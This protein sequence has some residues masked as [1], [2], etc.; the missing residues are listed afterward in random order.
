LVPFPAATNAEAAGARPVDLL[1]DES[2][3]IPVCQRIDDACLSGAGGERR[4]GKRVGFHVDHHE[5]LARRDRLQ[6]V[7]DPGDRISGRLDHNVDPVLRDC[8]VGARGD[9]DGFDGARV[10]AEAGEPRGDALR[11]EVGDRTYR[12]SWHGRRL[13]EEHG[14]ELAGSDQSHPYWAG[15]L[16][17]LSRE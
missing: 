10:P 7:I 2:R 4:P 17:P 14:A 15:L 12:D 6:R 16:R 1:G 11:T 3:L 8:L 13:G 5:V 9:L